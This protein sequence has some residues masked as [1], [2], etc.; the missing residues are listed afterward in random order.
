MA[1]HIGHGGHTG[2]VLKI[3]TDTGQ[4]RDYINSHIA[5]MKPRSNA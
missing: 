1:R 3:L 4:I 5:Q 2:M